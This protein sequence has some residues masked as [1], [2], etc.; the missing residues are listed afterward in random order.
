MHESILNDPENNPFTFDNRMCEV[1]KSQA[2]YG[3]MLSHEHDAELKAL[4]DK[5]DPKV[6]RP[7]DGMHVYLRR[8]TADEVAK[9]R[10]G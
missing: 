7:G 9:R 6:P 10:E 8:M 4:G 1:C 2:V 3:R 5:P